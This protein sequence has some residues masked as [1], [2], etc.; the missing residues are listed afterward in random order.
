MGTLGVE[1]VNAEVKKG[2]NGGCTL[3]IYMKIVQCNLLKWF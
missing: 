3:Y 1:R 2:E